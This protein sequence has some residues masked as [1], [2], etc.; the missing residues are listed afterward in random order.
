MSPRGKKRTEK[1]IVKTT[2]ELPHD[3]WRTVKVR[4][5][6]EGTDLRGIIVLALQQY[7]AKKG[8]RREE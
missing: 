3:L 7:L 6:D 5:M 1:E 2:V 8:A 4:A